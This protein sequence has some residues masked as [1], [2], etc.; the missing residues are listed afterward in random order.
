MNARQKAGLSLGLSGLIT[1]GLGI[2]TGLT[3]VDPPW[4]SI[5]LGVLTFC[6]PAL[7]LTINFPTNTGR[8]E[9]S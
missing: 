9:K 7:G 2:V 6:F 1:L 8:E 5:I 4:L 3:T